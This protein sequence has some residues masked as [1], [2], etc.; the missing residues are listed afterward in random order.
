MAE[1]KEQFLWDF[2]PEFL[3]AK[4]PTNNKS[5]KVKRYGV[6]YM[7]SK[8]Q[9]A[10]RLIAQMPSAKY[11]VDLFAGGCAMTHC[12]MLSGKY[13][14]FI[15]NDIGDAPQLFLDAIKGKFK[16]EKRWISREM[17]KELHT[18]DPY[19]RYIWS[20]GT[21]GGKNNYLYNSKLELFNKALWQFVVEKNPLPLREYGF[22]VT[23]LL[24]LPN[25]KERRL[26]FKKEV[27]RQNKASGGGAFSIV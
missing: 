5:Q 20:F 15:A 22:N 1:Y 10:E 4:T 14:R 27:V 9:I 3:G 7:G 23:S 18:S 21:K 11:F 19:I 6:G 8:N 13:E 25:S 26:A 17:Y 24:N 16:D 12:A 2:Y